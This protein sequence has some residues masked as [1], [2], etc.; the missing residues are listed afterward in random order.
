MQPEPPRP[1]AG[2]SELK[3]LLAAM[4]SLL[5][6]QRLVD[7]LVNIY[8]DFFESCTRVLHKPTFLAKLQDLR[9]SRLLRFEND[10]FA[11][12]LLAVVSVASSLHIDDEHALPRLHDRQ[13]GLDAYRLLQQWL[14]LQENTNM[15]TLQ[16]L[17][18][19]LLLLKP[20]K[21]R[22]N[23]AIKHWEDANS[24]VQTA[25]L[26]GLH[27]E[28][29]YPPDIF[30]AE[31]R[32]RLWATVI[33]NDLFF[34]VA[35]NMPPRIRASHV[36]NPLSLD[37]VELFPGMQ[38]A[39]RCRHTTRWTNSI[40]QHVLSQSYSARAGAYAAVSD[41]SVLDYDSLL[42]WTRSIEWKINDAP[43]LFRLDATTDEEAGSPARVIA[44]MEFDFLQRRPLKAIYGPYARFMPEDDRFEE[45]RIHW[46]QSAILSL[47]FQD[48]FDPKYPTLDLPRAQGLWDHFY[49]NYGWDVDLAAFATCLELQRLRA[50][51]PSG[52]D[53]ATPTFQSPNFRSPSQIKGWS[54][55]GLMKSM[56]ETLEPLVRRIAS[57]GHVLRDVV[58]W[59]MI[60][61]S[62]RVNPTC[63]RELSMKNELQSL[64]VILKQK[65]GHKA[66]RRNSGAANDSVEN[67][68]DLGSHLK[69][70]AN[71]LRQNRSSEPLLDPMRSD[72]DRPQH[73]RSSFGL[74]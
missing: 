30:E 39:P 18:V 35:C 62:L 6:E 66:V 15:R 61:G 13:S 74:R 9:Q 16:Y 1:Y 3:P 45:A 33:E 5:P 31:I 19:Q 40:C 43:Q 57:D 52:P 64:I 72:S 55:E 70:V 49:A 58:L 51:F 32:R 29:Q 22:P 26:L 20:H 67:S 12:T 68:L 21:S 48:L 25:L 42:G 7:D 41:G 2:P 53:L 50:L 71:F 63:H 65:F 17:Q 46:V 28:Q 8:F 11:A 73:N 23:N 27:D 44:Q 38:V 36:S 69:W 54:M 4:R 56:E 60:T 24:A 34:S 14:R 10:C 47:N 37:D 59:T